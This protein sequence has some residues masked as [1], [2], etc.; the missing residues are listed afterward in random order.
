MRRASN[1]FIRA[2][3]SRSRVPRT[4]EVRKIASGQIGQIIGNGLI[5]TVANSSPIWQGGLLEHFRAGKDGRVFDVRPGLEFYKPSPGT[6][7]SRRRVLDSSFRIKKPNTRAPQIA[8]NVAIYFGEK[9]EARREA[10]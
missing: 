10:T 4:T 6:P 7:L 9:F 1:G 5:Q 3:L 2:A 8:S